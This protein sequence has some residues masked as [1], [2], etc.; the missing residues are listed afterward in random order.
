MKKQS[1]KNGILA[2]TVTA[3]LFAVLIGLTGGLISALNRTSSGMEQVPFNLER[4]TAVRETN[5]E[6]AGLCL[7]PE[8]I[9]ITVNGERLG[10]SA[11]AN[12]MNELFRL[13]APVLSE[14]LDPGR[15]EEGSEE[16]WLALAKAE[17]TAYLRFHT[18]L[19]DLLIGLFADLY[20]ERAGERYVSAAN[21]Y[22]MFVLPYGERN[23]LRLAV[24]SA[25]GRIV[26]YRSEAP[27]A[28]LRAEDLGQFV[29][30]YRSALVPFAFAGEEYAAASRTEPVFLEPVNTRTMLITGGTALLIRNSRSEVNRLLRTFGVNPDKLLTTHDEPDGTGSY[31]DAQGVVYL[32]ESA[33]EY[34]AT[35]GGVPVEN[36]IGYRK[37][38]SVRLAEYIQTALSIVSELRGISK[39][40]AGGDAGMFVSALSSENGRVTVTMQY[41]FD[42]V[43]ISGLEPA[44][45][46]VFENECLVEASL[47]TVAVRGLSDRRDAMN[48]W[49]F[50]DYV[51]RLG[52]IPRN[53]GL[54]YRSDFTADSVSAEWAA[55][56][57]AP[58]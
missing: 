21:V 44:F 13:L 38:G 19:P 40:Y 20:A 18:E 22:E 29:R 2:P 26:L 7:L 52:V 15:A 4:I 3:V 1:S 41:S 34:A 27:A 48:E 54:V 36:W 33:F 6:E 39:N 16:V 8:F 58:K 10:L 17:N 9:G 57:N 30:S 56:A 11:H 53:V 49:W 31:I 55:L 35:D 12:T 51:E 5:P 24:R 14:E 47:N 28:V 32:R 23:D 50:F 45:T 46:A 37:P 43:R 42:N 25:D